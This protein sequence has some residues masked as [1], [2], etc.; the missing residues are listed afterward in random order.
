MPYSDYRFLHFSI[1]TLSVS[2]I[3]FCAASLD[4]NFTSWLQVVLKFN[5][6]TAI[7]NRSLEL[8]RATDTTLCLDLIVRMRNPK[9]SA[10]PPSIPP[11]T[12]VDILRPPTFVHFDGE[13]VGGSRRK[14]QLE[15][16]EDSSEQ[17]RRGESEDLSD[18]ISILQIEL[19]SS[20]SIGAQ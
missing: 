4:I 16:R 11:C 14:R 2:A 6:S 10:I 17:M 8:K 9:P 18:L 3:V 5:S 12:R 7:P 20:P 1:A 13:T 19:I 15:V